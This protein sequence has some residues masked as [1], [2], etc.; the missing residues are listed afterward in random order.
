M[1]KRDGRTEQATPKKRRDARRDGNVAR[2]PEASSLAVLAAAIITAASSAPGALKTTG[3]MMRHWLGSADGHSGMHSDEF[4]ST[5]MSMFLAWSPMVFAAMVVGIGVQVAQSGIALAPKTARPSLKALSISKG[6]KK[7]SP[8]QAG[9]TLARSV[10]KVVV[11][12]LALVGPLQSL[13]ADL[14][15]RDDLASVA[16]AVGRAVQSVAWRVVIGAVVIAAVDAIYNK[17]KWKRDLMMTKQEIIDESRMSE[18]DPHMKAA[19]KRR[20]MENRR[21]RGLLDVSKADVVV[22]NPTHYAVAL[23]YTDGSPAPQVIDKGTERSAKRIRK[24]A[25][26]H[27][28]P[29]IE[30]RP[31]ARALYRQV[32]VGS[33]VPEKFFD[34]VIK[35]LV[36][37]Y[38]RRGRF[39]DSL[40]GTAHAAAAPTP[41]HR[42]AL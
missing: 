32:R 20:G 21:R 31:L 24:I 10:L 41:D 23:A 22:T 29:I 42:G 3:V 4:V 38:W 26:R 37:A 30:N 19:R 11:V 40:R 1:G 18:G 2:A 27:G 9:I 8:V 5:A 28:V 33:Y 6:L 7:L 15:Q 35:V 25:N 13:E 16:G 14:P 36:A 39:P 34:D 12:G 17:R